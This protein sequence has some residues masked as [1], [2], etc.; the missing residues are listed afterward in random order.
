MS[1]NTQTLFDAKAAKFGTSTSSSTFLAL[2]LDAVNR[3]LVDIQNEVL[4]PTTQIEAVETDVDLDGKY[5]TV[6][7]AGIDFYLQDSHQFATQP[8]PDVEGRYV[9]AKKV[10]SRVYLSGLTL[11]PKFGDPDTEDEDDT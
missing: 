9:R 7:E 5:R 1:I 3:T 2:F 8:I 10:A 4:I 11:S 6:V